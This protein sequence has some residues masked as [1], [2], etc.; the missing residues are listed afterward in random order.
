MIGILS[1]R[2]DRV[3]INC[4]APQVMFVFLAFACHH[5][6][7]PETALFANVSLTKMTK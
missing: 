1:R 7:W 2:G 6:M 4:F 5:A 3:K